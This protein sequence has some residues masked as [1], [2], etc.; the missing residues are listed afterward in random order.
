MTLFNFNAQLLMSAGHSPTRDIEDIAK[1][2]FPDATKVYKSTQA[3]DRNGIDWF[4]ERRNHATVTVDAKVRAQD[5]SKAKPPRD[6]LALEIWSVIEAGKIGWTLDERKHTDAILW[7]WKDSGRY[8]WM[9]F[10]PLRLAFC[11]YL[12]E[13]IKT[14]KSARQET[15]Y[16]GRHYHSECIFVP[17]QVVLDAVSEQLAGSLAVPQTPL[18]D[19]RGISQ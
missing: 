14:Y 13:W 16:F 5:F 1:K 17:T 7:L 12:T 11:E 3:D 4:I 10:L 2:H 18:F 6:D 9:P 19:I 8:Q 15:E